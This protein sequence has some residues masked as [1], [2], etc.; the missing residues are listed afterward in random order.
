MKFYGQFNPPLDKGLFERYFPNKKSGFFIE[1]GAH[2]GVLECTCKFFEESMGWKGINVEPAPYTFALLEKNRPLG[3]NLNIALSDREGSSVLKIAIHPSR[4][5][6]FGNSSLSHAKEHLRILE[7]DKC[8]FRD[9]QVRT[10]T[11]DSMVASNQVSFVDLFVLDVEG[12]E[13]SV[14][15]GMNTVFPAVICAEYPFVGEGPLKEAILPKG[16][17]FDGF[18]H[19]NMI[20]VRK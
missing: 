16:Y 18:I 6:D 5:E 17:R 9:V 10:L 2:D 19:N 1:A 4:G 15:R 20:F 13:L 14:I 7:E 3:K 12:H 11:Y 8:S